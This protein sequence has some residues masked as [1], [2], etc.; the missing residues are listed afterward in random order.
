MMRSNVDLPPPLGPSNAVSE[1][2]GDVDRDV[3]QRDEIA[4]TL[5]DVL[6]ADS[7]QLCS[8]GRR[9]L[10]T[11]KI[12]MATIASV[13]ETAYAVVWSKFWNR[14]STTSVAVCVLPISRPDTTATA[15]Y[16]PSD[17]APG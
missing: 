10:I 11:I 8:F 12:K 4:E 2:A 13:T 17:R 7:H 15:P 6:G 9:T 1:P 5:G 3:V 16:S 14:S